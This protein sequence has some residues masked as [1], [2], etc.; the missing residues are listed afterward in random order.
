[1]QARIKMLHANSNLHRFQSYT[2]FCWLQCNFEWAFP[3]SNIQP[4]E[5]DLSDFDTLLSLF[6]LNYH[7]SKSVKLQ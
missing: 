5:M 4:F 6:E 7:I 1:M 2:N 3:V